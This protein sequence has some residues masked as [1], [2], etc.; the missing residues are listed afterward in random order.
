MSHIIVA[1]DGPA[2][3]GKSSVSKGIAHS[4]GFTLIDT[5]AMYRTVGVMMVRHQLG[6]D[7]PKL[8]Q[9]AAEGTFGF[10]TSLEGN[11]IFFNGED[12]STEIRTAAGGANASLVAKNGAIRKV[13]VSKQ[14]ELA[15]DQS[16]VMEGRDIGT[17]VF[18]DASIKLFLTA[19][20]KV[21]AQRRLL[22]FQAKQPNIT[23]DQV[24][25]EIN[26]R[27]H[28]DMTRKESPLKMA[29]DGVEVDT[30]DL[31]QQGVIDH[32]ITLIKTKTKVKTKAGV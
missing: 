29:D 30:S 2:G 21:R 11:K 27:D 18:P 19:R 9:I 31:T 3:V 23:L 17:V 32:C 22:E 10:E 4:M 15:A 6:V 13:L 14:R 26:A 5:G 12:L 24:L 25:T 7:D 8:L 28:Q 1:I 20:P 16:V